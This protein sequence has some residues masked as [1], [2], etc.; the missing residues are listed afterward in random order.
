MVVFGQERPESVSDL[1]FLSAMTSDARSGIRPVIARAVLNTDN[2]LNEA[3]THLTRVASVQ[4]RRL[5]PA[6]RAS[7][8][9]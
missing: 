8:G 5:R 6:S 3:T 1:A 9:N 4:A 2:Q 7:A